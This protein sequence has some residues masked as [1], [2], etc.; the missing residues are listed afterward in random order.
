MKKV[1]R[2]THCVIVKNLLNMQNNFLEMP[3]NS[4]PSQSDSISDGASQG[5]SLNLCEVFEVWV[6]SIVFHRAR[7]SQ[8]KQTELR[9][10]HS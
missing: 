5:R 2:E 1:R 7:S 8:C 9:Q 3:S 6:N 4:A 10:G